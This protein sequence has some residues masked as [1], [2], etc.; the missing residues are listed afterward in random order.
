MVLSS[1]S[2]FDAVVVSLLLSCCCRR[3]NCLRV[4][5]LPLASNADD[6]C[7]AAKKSSSKLD[8]RMTRA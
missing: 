7:G 6:T 1:S 4:V 3:I 2:I 8:T 5:A